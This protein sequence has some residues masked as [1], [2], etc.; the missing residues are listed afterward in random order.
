[1]QVNCAGHTWLFVLESWLLLLLGVDFY[2]ATPQAICT[3]ELADA[4]CGCS[5]QQT[6]ATE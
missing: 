5:V 4:V 3:A 1:M 6:A 2:V